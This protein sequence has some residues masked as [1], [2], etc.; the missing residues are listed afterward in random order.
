MKPKV[1][2]IVVLIALVASACSSSTSTASSAANK[3]VTL[4]VDLP[5]SGAETPNGQPTLQGVQ[6][7][8]KENPVPGYT[9]N[10][11]AK[12]DALNGKHDP[13][14]G[15]TNIGQFVNDPTVFAVVGPFNSNVAQ[16]EIPVSNAA[17][18]I[19]CSPANTATGL[20]QGATALAL[21]ATNPTKIAYV[22]VASTDDVQGQ[23]G[24]DIA[25]SVVGAKT[26]YV[27]DD[28]ETYG[29]GLA[30]SFVKNFTALGG[31]IV[32][33][34]GVGAS[35]QS[36][37]TA[38]L[39]A[40]KAKNPGYVFF[41][42]VTATGGGLLRKQMVQVGM[43]SI[44]FGGGDGISDGSA[45][46]AS[47]FLNVAGPDGDLNTYMTV[48]AISL[49]PDAA[50]FAADFKAAYNTAPGAY[51]ASGYACAQ[52]FL[53]ALKAV[54]S[55]REAVRAYVTT[56]TNTFATVLGNITFDANG[57]TSQHVISDYKFDPTT[58][59]WK[60]FLQKDF[61]TGVTTTAA[62]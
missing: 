59:D 11:V 22:R 1:L 5:L 40:A 30:D 45:A 28:T 43:G 21:R 26:A 29:K 25:Y 24:A 57:D 61:T 41:G 62:P 33:R 10:V 60:F 13:Q 44:P 20:T 51:S 48:A 36:D 15:A 58:K 7:A 42:G 37:Y 12:D 27:V 54:G 3:V 4:G 2:G 52:I 16:A 19:Q 8:V 38:L 35:G 14:T 49:I 31:T 32:G 50:K 9:V 6:L 17:G 56:T 55:G 23:A 53:Q 46:T 47:S 39:T 18:L 34:D